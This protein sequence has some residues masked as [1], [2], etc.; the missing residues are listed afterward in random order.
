MLYIDQP[1]QTGFSYSSLENV[2]NDLFG[3]GMEIIEPG[4]AIPK[5]NGTF[6]V[7]TYPVQDFSQTS[8]TTMN[9]ARA[10]WHFAQTFVGEFPEY[11]PKN[12]SLS[13]WSEGYGGKFAA[14]FAAYFKKQTQK[15]LKNSVP[16]QIDTVGVIN[17]L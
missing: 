6:L 15:Q 8:N 16:L 7:G 4:Q 13:I 2:T 5:Q 9:A 1:V 10:I 17:G 3:N 12:S 14:S 11:K